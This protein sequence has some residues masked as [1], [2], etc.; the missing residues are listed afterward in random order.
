MTEELAGLYAVLTAEIVQQPGKTFDLG[1]R[2]RM[3][4]EIA[5]QDDP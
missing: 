1:G 2:R 3:G 4:F 5:Q